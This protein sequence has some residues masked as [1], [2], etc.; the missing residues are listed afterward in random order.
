[1]EML[2]HYYGTHYPATSWL[3]E[4]VLPYRIAQDRQQE[5]LIK[6]PG[7]DKKPEFVELKGE[8]AH[9]EL[10]VPTLYKQYTEI[11][12]NG[13]VQF[14]GFNVDPDFSNCVDGLIIV[15]LNRLKPSKH[16][17]YIAEPIEEKAA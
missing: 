4:P 3:A 7:Q 16:A 8:L 15:D 1:M 12:E 13:G 11:C 14:A 17:R 9:M 10:N 2:V 6:F 5:L